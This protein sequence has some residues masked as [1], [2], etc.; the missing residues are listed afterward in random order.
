MIGLVLAW[1]F[2]NF[3]KFLNDSIFGISKKLRYWTKS[4]GMQMSSSILTWEPSWVIFYSKILLPFA[5][6]CH[7]L[8]LL[9][10]LQHWSAAWVHQII[11]GSVSIH[12]IDIPIC[13]TEFVPNKE[14]ALVMSL[15]VMIFCTYSTFSSQSQQKVPAFSCCSRESNRPLYS[16]ISANT[17]AES[18]S[19]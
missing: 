18:T 16:F 13:F 9:Y 5:L 8:L 19:T 3:L 12:G 10:P 6:H 11:A 1:F 14:L 17:E 2:L 4:H 7:C 15:S